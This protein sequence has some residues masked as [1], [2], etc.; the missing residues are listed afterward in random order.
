MSNS[1]RPKPRRV[2]LAIAILSSAV[3]AAALAVATNLAS[4]M[5]PQ[6]WERQPHYWT[7]VVIATLVLILITTILTVALQKIE[8]N[9]QPGH[10]LPSMKIPWMIPMETRSL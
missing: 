3:T 10:D 8:R 2:V 4:S 6:S 9:Q 7:W 1:H 5:I